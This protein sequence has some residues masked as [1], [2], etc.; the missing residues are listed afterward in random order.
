MSLIRRG[1]LLTSLAFLG[2]TAV[3]AAADPKSGVEPSDPRAF[4][5][6][7]VDT[8]RDVH[9]RGA[10]LYNTTKDYAGTARIYEGSLHTIRPILG[11]RPAAQKLID[12]GL[13]EADKE[14][15][16]ARRAFLLHE[17]ME[18]VRAN[19]KT[20]MANPSVQ[21]KSPDA[22]TPPKPKPVEAVDPSLPMP[23]PPTKTT[24]SPEPK[25]KPAPTADPATKPSPKTEP[26]PKP[27]PPADPTASASAALTG[28]TARTDPATQAPP[29]PKDSG[30]KAP[31]SSISGKVTLAGKPVAKAD[32]VLV[33][34][35]LPK[36]RVFSATTKNDGT[37]AMAESVPPAKYVVIVTGKDVP[38]KYATT[39]TS[40]L[41]IEVKDGGSYDIVLK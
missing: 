31:A 25:P 18:K 12:D 14:A 20:A 23:M 6:L 22:P 32:V 19:L 33:S 24:P 41:T 13:A 4:D 34:L 36:P 37:Y 16:Q 30:S 9:N 8:L 7:V 3:L 39:T 38:A 1:H 40:D 11:Y 5:K 26:T 35:T 15:D 17:T 27:A 21:P 29:L 10:D 2:F 28:S